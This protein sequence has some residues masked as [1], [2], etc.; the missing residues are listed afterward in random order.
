MHKIPQM[1]RQGGEA[2]RGLAGPGLASQARLGGAGTARQRTASRGEEGEAR[3]SLAG[4]AGLGW[5]GLS[6][7]GQRRRGFGFPWRLDVNRQSKGED[8]VFK[9]ADS[10]G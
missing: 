2:R 5:A 1:A 8:N 4:M 9:N 6:R 10:T 7:V 3:H